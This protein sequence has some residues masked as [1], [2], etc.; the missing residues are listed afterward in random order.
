MAKPPSRVT[1]LSILLPLGKSSP[2]KGGDALVRNANKPAHQID[3]QSSREGLIN[4]LR[5]DGYF[6]LKKK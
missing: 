4:R 2:P 5:R 6:E 3:I 1:Q